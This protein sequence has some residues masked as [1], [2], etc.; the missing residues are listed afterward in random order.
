MAWWKITGGMKRCPSSQ[1]NTIK[2]HH[3]GVRSPFFTFHI[4]PLKILLST[5]NLAP[6]TIGFQPN[7]ITVP[8]LLT[9]LLLWSLIMKNLMNK[10]LE[11]IHDLST[12]FHLQKLVTLMTFL[13]RIYWNPP[14]T[15]CRKCGGFPEFIIL[16]LDFHIELK[17]TFDLKNW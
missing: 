11:I 9:L 5:H 12:Y 17:T 16:C 6:F 3:N 10:S 7:C 15:F 2:V 4:F 14:Q 13:W 8:H 1:V